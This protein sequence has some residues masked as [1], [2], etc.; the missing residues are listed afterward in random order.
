[1]KNRILNLI[2]I[3]ISCVIIFFVAKGRYV[4]RMTTVNI[5]FN[6]VEEV[7]IGNSTMPVYGQTTVDYSFWD[8]VYDLFLGSGF[9]TLLI[10]IILVII[11]FIINK[12]FIK[13]ELKLKNYI[14]LFCIMFVLNIIVYRIG[15]NIAV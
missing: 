13:Q 12:F 5:D 6:I 9:P 15:I 7:K 3:I 8:N 4:N 2:F 10:A 14:F 1:M 11:S